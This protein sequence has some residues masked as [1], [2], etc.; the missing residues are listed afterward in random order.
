MKYMSQFRKFAAPVAVGAAGLLAS[1]VA[2]ADPISFAGVISA[3]DFSSVQSGVIS[4][5]ALL[6]GVYVAIKGANILL[7]FIR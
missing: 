1:A 5:A 6:A 2:S 3:V 4:V 7:G